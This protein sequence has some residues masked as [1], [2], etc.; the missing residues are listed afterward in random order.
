MGRDKALIWPF[1]AKRADNAGAY[2][3]AAAKALRRMRG[4]QR[5]QDGLIPIFRACLM[6]SPIW[7]QSAGSWAR[8]RR[9]GKS[10]RWHICPGLRFAP[11][12]AGNSRTA[13]RQDSQARVAAYFHQS[14]GRQ[15]SNAGRN[16]YAKCASLSGKGIA[17]GKFGL[18]SALAREDLILVPYDKSDA[19]VFSTATARKTWPICPHLS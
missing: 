14:A 4:R 15:D 10:L 5:P 6:K 8:L 11:D 19:P 17:G 12:A 18:Y 3:W 9:P 1:G 2:F 13:S 7:G 16:L